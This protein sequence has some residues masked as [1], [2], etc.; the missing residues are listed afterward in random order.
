[1]NWLFSLKWDPCERQER[2]EKGVF[3]V[4]HPHTPFLGQCPPPPVNIGNSGSRK[5]N[6]F[7]RGWLNVIFPDFS[8]REM[9]FRVDFPVK[10][11]FWFIQNK[12][13][14]FP[15]V[16]SRRKRVLFSFLYVFILVLLTIQFST[17]PSFLL[18]FFFPFFFFFF[19]FLFL[20]SLLLIGQ[21][22][23]PD[24]KPEGGT[25]PNRPS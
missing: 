19:F 23:F 5:R 3:R 18:F 24:E 16:K 22:K 13:Y 8:R 2:R 9:L 10:I 7:Q 20:A 4:A 11:T 12:I 15:K 25:L 1:M 14:W 6:I 21:Q 17:F